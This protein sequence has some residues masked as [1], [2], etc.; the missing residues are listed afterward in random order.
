MDQKGDAMK[1]EVCVAVFAS[2]LKR[3]FEWHSRVEKWFHFFDSQIV[4]GAIQRKSYGYH[5]F[6]CKS[7]R[8]N[9]NKVQDWWCS[10][11]IVFSCMY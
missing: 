7:D 6:F 5:T 10:V 9:P 1:A 11:L 3:Y 4:L 2:H 8:R